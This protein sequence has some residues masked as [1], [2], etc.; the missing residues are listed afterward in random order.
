[1]RNIVIIVVLWTIVFIV[2]FVIIPAL[3]RHIDSGRA[4]HDYDLAFNTMLVKMALKKFNCKYRI[5]NDKDHNG[6]LYHFDYQTGHFY[7]RIEKGTPYIRLT[8]PFFFSTSM[9]HIALVRSLS[10]QCSLS[11]EMCRIVYTLNTDQNL[12]DLHIV[13]GLLLTLKNAVEVLEREMLDMFR[14]QSTFVKRFREL[15][16]DN[17]KAEQK[18]FETNSAEWGRELFLLRE[19]E[20][21]HQKAGPS[22]RGNAD[23]KI[24]IEQLLNT[25]FGVKQFEPVCLKGPSGHLEDGKA[26]R[27]YDVSG[28]LIEKGKLIREEASLELQ[29]VDLRG[30]LNRIMEFHLNSENATDRTIY[31]RITITLIPLSVSRR[32]PS[33]S[34]LTKSRVVSL[35]AAYDLTCPKERLAEFHLMWEDALQKRKRNQEKEM[36][37][38]QKLMCESAQPK[39]AYLLFRG[40]RLF[41]NHCF[42]ES[43]Q[44]LLDAFN[45]AQSVFEDLKLEEKDRFYEVCYLIGFCYSELH[46]Y[47]QAYYYLDIVFPLHRVTYTEELVNS[48][49]NGHDFR[50]I[51]FID[52]LLENVENNIDGEDRENVA[53]NSFVN[54]L[55][56]RK[57][58]V[59]IDLQRYD[60]AEALLKRMLDDPDNTDFAIGE[61]AYLQK[62]KGDGK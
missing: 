1:M 60:E 37:E 58:Y 54:F 18:D 11:S 32:I 28:A 12:V 47:R 44:Y 27:N 2:A 8:Y 15:E 59:Y 6:V 10:N 56:R 22:W 17:Q 36:T 5:E 23:E 45:F 20:M 31:Y 7:I 4:L 48:L 57:A 53:V 33:G 40:K 61:L 19:Q 21:M 50:A 14:W 9:D 52:G 62:L 51:S 42:Y 38:E 13:S 39:L 26:I 55:N 3:R 49:V 43:L 41:L 46:L 35:L 30:P 16:D 24:T 25:L 34:E 29:Y